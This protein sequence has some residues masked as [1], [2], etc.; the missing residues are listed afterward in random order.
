[1]YQEVA[2]SPKKKEK[3]ALLNTNDTETSSAVHLSVPHEDMDF[4]K[5]DRKS[6]IFE[7]M[8]ERRV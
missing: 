3:K 1:M 2:D 4:D 6:S 7:D 5:V 8:A